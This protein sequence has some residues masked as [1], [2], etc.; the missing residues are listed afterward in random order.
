MILKTI[1]CV[2][3][4]CSFGTILFIANL[5]IKTDSTIICVP[6]MLE[7]V[8]I[9]YFMSY[10]I[11]DFLR[12]FNN[13][14]RKPYQMIQIEA[15]HGSCPIG[16]EQPTKFP[17]PSGCVNCSCFGYSIFQSSQ[18]VDRLIVEQ[19]FHLSLGKMPD[20]SLKI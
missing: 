7:H 12:T 20:G 8:V 15:S 10:S 16:F 5:L 9:S 17:G 1:L 18:S 19:L 13:Q 4:F 6:C 11:V 3:H 2:E 14:N